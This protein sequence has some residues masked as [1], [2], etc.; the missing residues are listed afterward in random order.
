M[1]TGLIQQTGSLVRVDYAGGGTRFRIAFEKKWEPSLAFGESMAVQGVCLTVVLTGDN[2]FECDVL[3]ETLKKTNLSKKTAGS[4]LNLERALR[5][6]DLL[7]GH[8]VSGH[9]DGT[10]EVLSVTESGRDKILK[11]KCSDEL[12]N[13]MV[14]KG[15]IC[16]DG[17]SLT[18]AE[19]DTDW[20]TVH[21]IPTTWQETS[22]HLLKP[23]EPVNIENDMLGKFVLKSMKANATGPGDKPITMETL[24]NAGFL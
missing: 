6:G 18:I 5:A 1:F 19:L 3:Q 7:G 11:V 2:W 16:C 9:I 17:V 10:G 22:L 8:M 14:P 24:K 15:S 23:S 4:L 13:G 21:L 12:M 20:F